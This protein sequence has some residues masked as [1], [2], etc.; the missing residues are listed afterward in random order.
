MKRPRKPSDKARMSPASKLKKPMEQAMPLAT[1]QAMEQEAMEQE[2][3]S[4]KPKQAMEQE[5]L[6]GK[7]EV[8]P[9]SVAGDVGAGEATGDIAPTQVIRPP[10]LAS[11]MPMDETAV[12]DTAPTQ[13]I[14][15]SSDQ[16]R[17]LDLERALSD[18]MDT[19]AA[20]C[21][22]PET[23]P[24]TES[25]ILEATQGDRSD[26]TR[27]A[28]SASDAGVSAE[29]S[30]PNAE[31]LDALGAQ[32]KCTETMAEDSETA[33]ATDEIAAQTPDV[34]DGAPASGVVG[35]TAPEATRAGTPE[36][37][38]LADSEDTWTQNQKQIDW[39][40]DPDQDARS[41]I[42]SD[43]LDTRAMHVNGQGDEAEAG[44]ATDVFEVA[45]GV[46]SRE[47]ILKSV[48]FEAKVA[49]VETAGV[50]PIAEDE[51]AEAVG[52]PA[53][54]MPRQRA[55][56][57]PTTTRQGVPRRTPRQ[58]TARLSTPMPMLRKPRRLRSRRPRKPATPRT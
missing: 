2:A 35:T 27:S 28:P 16:T 11:D 58:A 54:T 34:G 18:L 56:R 33:G 31:L 15:G 45:D 49:G 6:S 22:L 38:Q 8:M 25:Q 10:Q 21:T 9:E 13:I 39:G 29:P 3:L 14:G 19:D 41:T 40:D 55:P 42:E 30:N 44:A 52:A 32:A 48:I 47:E 50:P 17:E 7:E 20:P 26:V 4:G 24:A 36:L 43:A 5:A 57:S 23:L 12:E 1:E 53:P 37:V 51:V 46:D